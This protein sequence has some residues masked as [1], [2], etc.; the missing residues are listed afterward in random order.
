MRLPRFGGRGAEAINESLQ[1]LALVFLI[2]RALAIKRKPF[3]PLAHER[4]VATAIKRKLSRFEMENPRDGDVEEIAFVADHH[5]GVGISRKMLLEPQR[6]FK[7]E[8]IGRLVQQQ[9]VGL[10][11]SVAASATRMRQP[12]ENCAQGRS[13]SA[14]EKPRPYRI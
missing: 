1:S 2:F 3:A 12:P 6:R 5:D 11:N 8:I 7:I 14:W 4:G 9:K 10:Q 13:W